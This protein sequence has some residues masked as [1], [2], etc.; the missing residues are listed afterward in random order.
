MAV[1]QGAERHFRV[2]MTGGDTR[3]RIAARLRSL[4][5]PE[6]DYWDS[7]VQRNGLP[8][9]PLRF[10]ALALGADGRPIP[11]VNTDPAMLLLLEPVGAARARELVDPILR[12]YPQGLFVDGLG[13]L[14]AN[15]AYAGTDVWDAFRRDPY[16]SPSVVWGRD[17]NVL[18]AGLATQLLAGPPPAR[19][20]CPTPHAKARRSC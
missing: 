5:P 8:P 2:V 18:L 4:P 19:A 13:P 16:H 6:R 15:D 9:G 14:V 17:V 7:L 12:P 1:W 10:L 11:I 3:E 20:R